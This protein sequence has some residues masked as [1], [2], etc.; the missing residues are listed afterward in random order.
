LEGLARWNKD[1]AAS[2][3]G[4]GTTTYDSRLVL[5]T[6]KLSEEVLGKPVD[7]TYSVPNKYTS[8]YLY[9]VFV[10]SCEKQTAACEI[11]LFNR[12]NKHRV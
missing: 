2:V 4:R 10:L 5:A 8:R 12:Q 7:A 11:C 3:V 1:R 6:N 9:T